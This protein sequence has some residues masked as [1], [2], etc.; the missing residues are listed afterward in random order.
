MLKTI[1]RIDD[2]AGIS[3]NNKIA[4]GLERT[5]F[6]FLFLMVLSAPHSIAATQIAWLTGMF[7]SVIRLF[8]RPRPGL[9]RSPMDIPLWA[10]FAWAVVVAAFSYEP[11]I[12]LGKLRGAGLFLIFYF[13]VNNLR[14]LRVVRLMAVSLILS[15]MVNVLWM[16]VERILGRGVEIHGLSAES[17]LAKALL[18]EGDALLKADGVKI[19]SPAGLV[20]AIR[21]HEVS[22]IEFYRP[23]FYFTVE[24][25]RADL[26]SGTDSIQILG[27]TGWKKS[28]N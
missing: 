10:F 8:V 3:K 20:G 21:Q 15:C 24:V 26:L 6:V 19:E 27:I 4:A 5:A 7:V 23:D 22:R 2:F 11:L 28:R 12:S 17:P 18:H 25:R 13:V 1:A 16:P 14:S 9:V